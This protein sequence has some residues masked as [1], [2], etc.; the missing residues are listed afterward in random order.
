MLDSKESSVSKP[1]D[2]MPHSAD[3]QKRKE[4]EALLPDYDDD[5]LMVHWTSKS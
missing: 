4:Q 2:K 1:D 5:A 3:S